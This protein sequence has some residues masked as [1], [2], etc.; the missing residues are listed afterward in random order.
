[1]SS[2]NNSD[3]ELS[4]SEDEI[5]KEALKE[6]TD[7]NFLK[8]TLFATQTIIKDSV[9]TR[10]LTYFLFHWAY[11]LVLFNSIISLF[12]EES[13][14]KF[15]NTSAKS[16]RKNVL[17]EDDFCNFGVSTTFKAYVAKK[18]DALLERQG[19]KRKFYI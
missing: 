13:K 1:M 9:I 16:L 10:N 5:S 18:L 7:I 4:S 12:Q 11:M 3:G 19:N 2:K 6:A 15:D 8:P 17:E 14:E